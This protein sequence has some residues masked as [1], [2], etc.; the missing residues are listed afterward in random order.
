MSGRAK[1]SA[2]PPR[3]KLSKALSVE[4]PM[5]KELPGIPCSREPSKTAINRYK[6]QLFRP[7]WQRFITARKAKASHQS[8]DRESLT[9]E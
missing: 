8:S 9:I 7:H 3:G 1:K 6:V 4:C 2:S 5:C